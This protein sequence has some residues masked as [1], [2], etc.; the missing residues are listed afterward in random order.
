MNPAWPAFAAWGRLSPPGPRGVFAMLAGGAP[1]H[2]ERYLARGGP[3][4]AISDPDV[5]YDTSSYG[6]RAL[7]PAVRVVRDHP[8][9]FWSGPPASSGSTSSSSGRIG[10]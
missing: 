5:F 8:L 7:D 2:H 1:L 6:R 9:A 3:S 4:G 10:R